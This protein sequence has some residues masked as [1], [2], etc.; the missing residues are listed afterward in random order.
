ML[1]TVHLFVVLLVDSLPGTLAEA[2]GNPSA[3]TRIREVLPD[4]SVSTSAQHQTTTAQ[5]RDDVAPGFNPKDALATATTSKAVGDAASKYQD[6]YTDEQMAKMRGPDVDFDTKTGLGKNQGVSELTG[7]GNK[8]VGQTVIHTSRFVEKLSE[9]TDDMNITGALSIKA[10]MFGGSGRGAYIDTNKFEQSDLNFYISVK[11]I[12]QSVNFKD[13]LKY[14]PVDSVDKTNFVDVFGDTFISGFLEGGEFNA[15]VSMKILNSAK[16]NVIAAEAKVALSVPVVQ[17]TAEGR[18]NI[19]KSNINTNAETTIQVSWS[20]GGHIKDANEQWDVDSLIR[21]ASRFPDLVAISPQRIYA[22]LTKY[23]SLRS[24]IELKPPNATP[25]DYENAKLY[26]NSLMDSYMTYKSLYQESGTAIFD[27]Q[28]GAKRFISPIAGASSIPASQDDFDLTPFPPT[29]VG[30]D[31]ARREIRRQMSLIVKEVKLLTNNP[32]L[33]SDPT[34]K[35]PSQSPVS[36]QTR[37]PKVE[38]PRIMSSTPL[39]GQEIVPDPVVEDPGAPELFTRGG[40]L[41]GNLTADET[42]KTNSL[43]VKQP[44]LSRV[45]RMTAPVGD[46]SAGSQFCFLDYLHE[47]CLIHALKIEFSGG[48]CTALT[49]TYTNGLVVVRGASSPLSTAFEI[50][51]FSG[52]HLI[53]GSIEVGTPAAGADTATCVTSIKLYTNRGRSLIAT[54]QENRIITDTSARRDGVEYSGLGA[55]SWDSPLI[56]G[57]IKGF[58]GRSNEKRGNGKIYRLGFFWGDV[59]TVS[60]APHILISKN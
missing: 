13:A 19:A 36:F 35:E 20:G 38:V 17:V 41:E 48:A 49:T 57:F 11:V 45:I 23:D 5:A 21:A 24:F 55:T 12:N 4:P 53:A 52:D 9:V 16:K 10:S 28:S 7:Y 33:A 27:V 22:I 3:W 56:S 26:T 34:H 46:F 1:H 15:L 60:P 50:S 2:A 30:L 54:A 44:S 29:L 14:Q 37:L 25:L 47:D 6:A 31:Q 51:N 59:V 40:D 42:T 32:T 18:V 58:W 8:S 39:S 43:T